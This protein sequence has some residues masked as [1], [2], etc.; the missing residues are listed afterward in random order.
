MAGEM[1]R[2]AGLI[3]LGAAPAL[4]AADDAV[5]RAIVEQR[6][7]EAGQRIDAALRGTADAD[8]RGDLLRDRLELTV[9]R[10]R[11]GTDEGTALRRDLADHAAH[12]DA[13]WQRRDAL[14]QAQAQVPANTATVIEAAT[15]LAAGEASGEWRAEALDALAWSAWGK[16][17]GGD[18]AQRAHFLQALEQALGAWQAL[19]GLHARRH[20]FNLR[21]L[22]GRRLSVQGDFVASIAQYAEAAAYAAPVFGRDSVPVLEAES[23]RASDLES[24]GRY[25]EERDLYVDLLRRARAHL[26]EEHAYVGR[27]EA[28]LGAM[29]AQVGDYAG[30]RRHYEQAERI[31]AHAPD[32]AW[33]VR[34][35]VAVNF[36]NALQESGDG[37]A[38]RER[39]LRALQWIDT[40]PGLEYARP[41]VLAN[42]GNSE[43]GLRRYADAAAHFRQALALREKINGAADPGL[44]FALEGLGSVALAQAHYAEA[45]PYFQWALELRQRHLPDVHPILTALRFGLALAQWGAGE[46]DAAFTLAVQAAEAQ[47]RLVA[48][49]ASDYLE[50]QSL[51]FRDKLVP[52]TALVVTL[53]AG[54]GD[55]ASAATAWRL[56]MGERGLIARTQARRLA[57]ARAASDP[58]QAQAWQAWRK[59]NSALAA[60][61][62]GGTAGADLETLRMAAEQAEGQLGAGPAAAA[63]M[64]APEI[65]VLAAALP[66]D[67]RLLAV[68]EGL[69]RE[70]MHG[71]LETA[72]AGVPQEWYAF[73]LDASARPTLRRL[74]SVAAITADADAW[75]AALRDPRASAAELD[76][77]GGAVARDLMGA[78]GSIAPGTLFIVP[79]GELF[80]LDLAALPLAGGFAVEHGLQAHVLTHEA[81]LLL[82]PPRGEA[83]RV[84]LAGA[85]DFPAGA[86]T[87]ATRRQLCVRAPQE[88]FAALASAARELRELD[89]LFAAR[90]EPVERLSGA[91]ATRE[92]VLAALP[93]VQVAH[94]AT[95]GFSLDASC[96]AVPGASRSL[97]LQSTAR[98]AIAGE[99]PAVSG[100]AFSGAHLGA[101]AT[102]ILSDVDLA[103]LDLRGVDW[104]ALSA[105]DSGL[106]PVRRG[107]GVFGMRR[108]LRLA[109]ARTVVMSLWEVDDEATAA[110]MAAVY[111]QRFGRGRDVPTAMAAAQRETLAARRAAGQ[112]VHPYY[113]AAFV[114]E[115]GWR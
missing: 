85:P 75:Y 32:V 34:L 106:G 43:F 31:L 20:E 83:G 29:L 91:A 22:R 2:L 40:Q 4:A 21:V 41:I 57:A 18:A 6:F 82:P 90:H 115:G 17:R 23:A 69:S 104:I 37:A 1:A 62:L 45:A 111:A 47:Q 89:A 72:G 70:Q 60:A 56:A 39:Q 98:E 64:Q 33:K 11:L 7:V 28:G 38:A 3:V 78:D 107:E 26:G 110:L 93:Q 65:A 84:L 19:P 52:A 101:P 49:V 81:D 109:G 86:G 59:A 73:A 48:G 53:A 51:G 102:G 74:G 9:V 113:W 77:R 71:Q 100:L 44:A 67:A 61:W 99:V 36:A 27:L 96:A 68:T 63:A 66:P 97:T 25:A 14:L 13:A 10:E 15:A 58:A 54:R 88:G 108:A 95:H 105:C 94:L 114:A 79:A 42:L 35:L 80:R 76:R 5:Q 112:S 103:A 92:R 16:A 12:A 87:G 50:R 30:A 46:R 8:V 24:L 55:A